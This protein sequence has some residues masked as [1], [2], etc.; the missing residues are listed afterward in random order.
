MN[1]VSRLFRQVPPQVRSRGESIFRFRGVN[2]T[3][4]DAYTLS[5]LVAGSQIYDVNLEF[6]V[7]VISASCACPYFE[8][9]GLCKHIWATVLA[10]DRTNYLSGADDVAALGL[11]PADEFEDAFETDPF[12]LRLSP[13]PAPVPRLPQ[14]KT[15]LAQTG[16]MERYGPPVEQWRPGREIHYAIDIESTMTGRGLYL[17]VAVRDRKQNGELGRPKPTAFSR[18]EIAQIPSALDREIVAVLAGVETYYQY[19]DSRASSCRL[20]GALTHLLLPKLCATGHCRLRADSR[21]RLESQTL[22]AWDQGPPWIF[23]MGFKPEG[24]DWIISGSFERGEERMDLAEPAL[25]LQDGLLFARGLVSSF[26]AKGAFRWIQVL[27]SRNKVGVPMADG[28]EFLGWM[29]AQPELPEIDW[30]EELRYEE[31]A[32]EPHPHFKI[33]ESLQHLSEFN[34]ALRGFLTFDYGGAVFSPEDASPGSYDP[35][36][37]RFLKRDKSAEDAASGQL[38]AMGMKTQRPMHGNDTRAYYGVSAKRLPQ[39]V[40]DLLKAGWHVEAEGKAFR[41]ASSFRAEVTSGID[42]FELHAAADYGAG[43]VQLPDLLKALK[44]GTNLVQ[45]GDGSYGVLPEELLK[46]YGMLIGLGKA[47]GDHIRYSRAQT[48][49]LDA[50]LATREDVK[51]DAVFA[52]AREQLRRFEGIQPAAQPA[53]FTGELRTYQREGV[54]WMGFLQ[55]LGFGGCVADDMGVGKTAQVLALLETRRELRESGKGAGPSLVVVPRSIVYNWKQESERFTPRLRVLDHSG[56]GRDKSVERFENYDLILTTYGTLRRDA[57]DFQNFRFDYIV[58]DEAQ[59]IKNAG[60]E[61]A[62]AARLLQGNHRLVMSGTP[63]EN[64][65]GELWSLFEF[66]NPGMLGSLSAVGPGGMSMKNPDEPTR[67]ILSKALRPFILRRTKDQVAKEL[68]QKL[69]QTVYCEL[70][71]GQ[72]KLYDELRDHY[73]RALLGRIETQGIGKSK[74]QILEALLRLRQAAC[75]PGLLDP[76]RKHELGAKLEVLMARLTEVI[77][78][79][80]KALVFSQFTSLLH[81]VRL[82]LDQQ[83]VVYEYLDGKVRDRQSRVERFQSD[84]DCP[85]FLISLKAG[86]V[87]LNLTAAEYVFLLDP[88]WNPAVEAQA[89][90]RAHRIGQSKRVFA[91]RLIAKDTVEEKVLELQNTKRNLADAIIRADASLVRDL[92][93]EDLEFLFS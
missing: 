56:T 74:M 27:R 75:H 54:A 38:A 70:D 7:D 91:Y 51:V 47:H 6:L 18:V 65:L 21:Q 92:K 17:E 19:S 58:L 67:V 14:W 32:P 31:M 85:L 25:L 49:L 64:H 9:E 39:I 36:Q 77:A 59:A 8:T 30:P 45:L 1:L 26:D 29:L 73:R 42:W 55:T 2:I 82:H 48:G 4:G 71:T 5:A 83:S 28:E 20:S 72:R 22:L 88:W 68:P 13:G 41:R 37:R 86:G 87:G 16:A 81:I 60:T 63:I 15:L 33:A 78:E 93:R 76:K 90:D 79:G 3:G 44:Q 84:P 52:A 10:A 43:V 24:R 12:P 53:G 57:V 34:S 69:E 66:L 40:R 61:S 62:K 35:E 89:I 46:Q 50:L 11:V 23:R 80:H